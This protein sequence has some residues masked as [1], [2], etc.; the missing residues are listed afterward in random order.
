M[1]ISTCHDPSNSLSPHMF[2]LNF[3]NM[4][5]L[6]KLRTLS[7]LIFTDLGRLNN[8][9]ATK[10]DMLKEVIASIQPISHQDTKEHTRNKPIITKDIIKQQRIQQVDISRLRVGFNSNLAATITL[11]RAS[12]ISSKAS[13]EATQTIISRGDSD[14]HFQR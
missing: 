12:S 4:P 10:R 2:S 7:Q 9:K 6:L 14:Q 5:P 11:L 3:L 8:G 13:M 1:L